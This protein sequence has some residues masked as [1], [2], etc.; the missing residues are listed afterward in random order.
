MNTEVVRK[1]S[2]PRASG[3]GEYVA[4][5]LLLL[6]IAILV[7]NPIGNSDFWAHAKTG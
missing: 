7:F 2:P 1:N 3:F 5:A 6:E 4:V